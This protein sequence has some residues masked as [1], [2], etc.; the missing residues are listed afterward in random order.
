MIDWEEGLIGTG[1]VC[2]LVA[3]WLGYG[4]PGL[5]VVLGC[6]LILAGVGVALWRRKR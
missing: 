3:A 6:L 4:W 5:L 1:A 2:I